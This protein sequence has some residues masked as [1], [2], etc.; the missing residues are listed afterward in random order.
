MSDHNPDEY[1]P[2]ESAGSVAGIS[3]RT[4]RY[5]IKGGKLPAIAG[6]RGKLVRLGDV[7]DMA[8]LT[9]KSAI[10]SRQPVGNVGNPAT[11]A[12]RS[13]GNVAGNDE[14][15][16]E[17]PAVP[18]AAMSQLEA[19]RDEWLQ[20]LID[21]I[22]QLEHGRGRLE[23]QRDQA[24]RER[25]ELTQRLESDRVLT[26]QIVTS[27]ESERDILRAELG[28]LR[29]TS[30]VEAH[31]EIL[32]AGDVTEPHRESALVSP[33]EAPGRAQASHGLDLPEH[34]PSHV[35]GW[36]RRLFGRS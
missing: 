18:P 2:V 16:D 21:Q 36:L 12:A 13:A 25:D 19:V 34:Q 23:E 14:L 3:A 30:D 5:W 6:Q 26:D 35:A 31:R 11:S 29:A 1:L 4:L 33:S 15:I 22:R 8:E 9:G 32:A 27:L 20:P 10:D 7:L 24:I 17:R 28:H